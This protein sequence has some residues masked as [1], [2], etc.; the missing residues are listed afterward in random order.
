MTYQKKTKPGLYTLSTQVTYDDGLNAA[1][2]HS[3]TITQKQAIEGVYYG[4]FL[5]LVIIVIITLISRSK[6]ERKQSKM[7]KKVRNI[8]RNRLK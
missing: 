6:E 1:S 8:V 7:R 4:I 5:V 3:F 2:E